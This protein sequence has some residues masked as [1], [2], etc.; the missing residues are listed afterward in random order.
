MRK[1]LLILLAVLFSSVQLSAQEKQHQVTITVYQGQVSSDGDQFVYGYG[2][3]YCNGMKHINNREQS[4]YVEEGDSA[5]IRIIP[6]SGHII[7]SVSILKQANGQQLEY[8]EDKQFEPDKEKVYRFIDVDYDLTMSVTFIDYNYLFEEAEVD[9]IRYKLYPASETAALSSMKDMGE[10]SFWEGQ[11]GDGYNADVFTIPESIEHNGVSYAVTAIGEYGFYCSQIGQL[12][13]PPS[14]KTIGKEAFFRCKMSKLV[15][16][17]T[18]TDIRNYAFSFCQVDSVIFP[19]R[20]G[21]L[22]MGQGLFRA[23]GSGESGMCTTKYVELPK[24][25]T[26]I[27]SQMFMLTDLSDGI[28]LPSTVSVIGRQAFCESNLTSI[29]IP[30]GVESIPYQAFW[31]NKNLR[32]VVLPKSMTEIA[33]YAFAGTESLDTMIVCN[34]VPPLAPN[35]FNTFTIS[36][37]LVPE[38]AVLVVPVGSKQQYQD[39]QG[40]NL[41]KTIVESNE[42]TGVNALRATVSKEL[43]R[44][45][46]DGRRLKSPTKGINIIRMSDGTVR[47]EIVK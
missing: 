41:F 9:G 38:T 15:I 36:T 23:T 3:V 10:N 14:I 21:E 28:V 25:M 46:A 24:D 32:K 40:W 26:E 44:Y 29:T 43:Q 39:A 18:V 2:T 35:M 27:P 30:E 8:I 6:D 31:Y 33:E 37:T 1:Y 19:E 22:A 20:M 11:A 45:S 5:I 47:K 42:L 16:P 7:Q 12:V 4:F 34:P 13:I 17:S